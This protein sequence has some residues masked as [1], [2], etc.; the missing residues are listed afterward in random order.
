MRRDVL[1]LCYHA[2]SDRWPATLAVSADRLERQVASLLER[3]YRAT[4]FTE[5]TTR[6]PGRRTLAVTFDDAYRSVVREAHPVLTEL[7]I[8]ATVF[9]PT[10]FAGTEQPMSWPGIDH[11]LEGPHAHELTPASWSELGELS[12]SGW[13][14]GSHT[15]D[16]PSLPALADGPLRDQLIGSRAECEARL[17]I[18]CRS[19][20]YPYGDCDRRVAAAAEAAGYEAGAALSGRVERGNRFLWP[21]VG[22]YHGDREWRFALKASP[23]V[24]RTR[25]GALSEIRAKLSRA[26]R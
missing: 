4:T 3:G 1:V 10:A 9:V 13:E 21:R 17:G 5:A 14:I 15:H 20:A 16:H 2:V 8:R 18:D 11:W 24:R 22:V 23:L 19:I 6:P 26:G 12:E 25:I 7:G